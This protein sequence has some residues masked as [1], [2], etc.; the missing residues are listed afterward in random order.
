MSNSIEKRAPGIPVADPH[1]LSSEQVLERIGTT[2]HGLEQAEAERRLQ[3]FGPNSLPRR[4]PPGLP[5]VFFAQFKSPLI[6]VL[7]AAAVVS[8]AIG[9]HSDALFISAVLLLNAVI[10][11]IQEYS[12]QRSADALRRLMVAEVRVLRDGDSV[13][14]NSEAV[15]PGDIV[16]LE[17]GERVPADMRIVESHNF[18]IDES[19]LSGE[20]IA[21]DKKADAVLDA[22]T[23]LGDRVNMAFAGSLVNRGRGICV[24][25]ATAGGTELGAIAESVAEDSS[26]KAPL[27]LRME[28]FTHRVAILIGLA[29]R[30]DC[31]S[32]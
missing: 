29:A 19:L 28:R 17:S 7:L 22:A 18:E 9:E 31:R 30:K 23:V 15:V 27:Q 4:E 32:R 10:G 5:Q 6:Y 3:E 11:T 14:I 24:V 12:A 1:A 25:V 13:E 16:L 21:V 8:V 20:S 2:R 26:S